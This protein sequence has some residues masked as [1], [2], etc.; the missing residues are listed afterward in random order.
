MT[1]TELIGQNSPQLTPAEKR[2]AEM[3]LAQPQL[4]AFGTVAELA[5]AAQVGVATVLRLSSK[6][7]FSGFSTLQTALQQDMA[8][9][10]R[11]AA[12]R[13]HERGNSSVTQHLHVEINNIH[14]TLER[15]TQEQLSSVTAM[16]GDL[17]AQV[18]VLSG[19]A[20]SG[21]AQQLI[22]DLS[23]LRPNVN[24]VAGNPVQVGRSVAQATSADVLLVMDLRRYDAWL[25]AAVQTAHA[26]GLRII[27]VTD[28]VLS[29]LAAWAHV[30]LLVTAVG[31]GPFDSHVGTLALCNVLVSSVAQQLH[32]S[33]SER[34]TQAEQA[35]RAANL[36][37]DR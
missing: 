24:F 13:I 33:A 12:V 21:V 10:L 4:V 15:L 35:W 9:W 32:D 36:L 5:Q 29:P 14:Q 26:Q 2:V 25:I 6:L 30:V 31:G 1:L 3:L 16:L 23:A 17:T 22:E 34:L 8:D 11:P 27:V 7:G 28:S 19:N 20:S 18:L 37:V